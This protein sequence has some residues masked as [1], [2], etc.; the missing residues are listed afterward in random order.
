ML[1]HKLL[2]FDASCP[3]SNMIPERVNSLVVVE[4]MLSHFF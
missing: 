4:G 1:K 3:L 2:G